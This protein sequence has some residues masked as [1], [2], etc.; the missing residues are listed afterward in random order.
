MSVDVLMPRLSDSMEEGT[1]V[2]WL[3]QVGDEVSVGEPLLEVETDK[4]TIAYEAESAGTLIAILVEEG[5]TAPLGAALALIGDPA[6]INNP[7]SDSPVNARAGRPAPAVV[8]AEP[9]EPP[10]PSSPSRFDASP[11]ARRLAQ[12]LGVELAALRGTGPRG[13]IVKLDVLRAST[14]PTRASNGASSGEATATSAASAAAAGAGPP[15]PSRTPAPSPA[16]TE[17]SRAVVPA[18]PTPHQVSSSTE[19][20]AKGVT[21]FV[22]FTRL[23]ETVARRMAQSRAT[24]PE[25]SLFRDVDMAEAVELRGRLR[26]MSDQ[27]PSFNDMIVKAAAVALRAY[28]LANSSYADS[29]VE[30]HGRVNVGIAV[31]RDAGLVVPT[32]TDADRKS[33]G[34]IAREARRLAAAVRDGTTMPAELAG[35][36]FTV[37]N[38]GMFGVDSFAAIINPGQAAILSVGRMAPR[39]V[40]DAEGAVVVRPMLTLGLISDHRVL[41]GADAAGFLSRICELLEQPLGMAL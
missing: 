7:A 19:D 14:A 36:T 5:A 16:P 15:A 20:G 17:P 34:E 41:Y 32:I 37:T 31:S 4:A 24:I 21:E 22:P 18:A 8:V 23:Q 1:I 38:L 9:V 6:E 11:V 39:A 33:L 28:P 10:A 12:H 27:A 3:K 2:S 30:L 40:V 25:F 13:R 35:G 29:G 26:A